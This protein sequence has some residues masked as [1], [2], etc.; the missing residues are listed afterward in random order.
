MTALGNQKYQTQR[1]K[2]KPEVAPGKSES[3]KPANLPLSTTSAP[4]TELSSSLRFTKTSCIGI[5][6]VKL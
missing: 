4:K 5:R 2:K 6:A 1:P 3:M